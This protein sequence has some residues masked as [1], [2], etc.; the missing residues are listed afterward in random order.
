[1][2]LRKPY[3]FLMKHFKKINFVLF[4]LTVYIFLSTLRLLGYTGEYA[5]GN[6]TQID[7]IIEIFSGFYFLALL[8]I[9]AV[10]IVLLYLLKRKDKPIKTYII[11]L[12]EYILMLILSIYL[13]GYFHD[14]LL[15]GYDRAMAR[16]IQ[17]FVRVL[18]LP[19]YA[20]LLLLFI[21]FMGIDLNSFGFRQD[22]EFLAN[23]EDREE[24][25]VE[26]GFD[27]DKFFRNVRM[28]LRSVRYF[29]EE[30][31]VQVGIVAGVVLLI[32]SF[33]TYRYFY[34]INRVYK[35]GQN[36]SSNYYNF[37]VN[38]A[39]ITTRDYRGDEI[40]VG[41][42]YVIID[43]DVKN[44]LKSTR[45]LDV[46]KFLLYVD[47]DYYVPT[48]NYNNRFEDLGPVFARQSLSGLESD[49][50]FLIYEID[51]PS[52]KS[53]FI[54]KY[55]HLTGQSRLIRIKLQI[56]DISSFVLRDTKALTETMEI[57]INKEDIKKVRISSYEIGDEFEYTYEQCQINNCPIYRD[58]TSMVLGRKVLFMKMNP[59]DSS[60]QDLVKV[61]LRYGK[62]QYVIDGTTYQEDIKSRV[63]RV[64]KGSYFY[65]DVDSRIEDA[66][67]I[68][69]VLTIRNNQYIYRIK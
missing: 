45:T 27:K 13:N 20:I 10:T 14:F 63:S 39:Y 41:K 58:I 48:L 16:T 53:D 24:V 44:T 54:L 60:A 21:R 55:Q 34:V 30:H 6:T 4:L 35:I 25:E 62:M 42:S 3:A 61:F 51:T 65:F 46:E 43:L 28:Y 67:T 64:Y 11:I 57:P 31:K 29:I 47:D 56:Q 33:F 36:I 1:M 50:Y 17:G 26:V 69:I 32:A 19:Q 49:N 52:E 2:I 22:Q 37:K 66:T 23:E 68:E 15:N 7:L 38:H 40:A 9:L 12:A 8:V 18:S 5:A 59:F